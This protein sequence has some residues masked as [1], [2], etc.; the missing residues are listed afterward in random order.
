M[1]ERAGVPRRRISI[2]LGHPEAMKRAVRDGLGI[3][4]LFRSSVEQELE[5]GALRQLQFPDADFSSPI[6]LIHRKGK[7]FSAS[8]QDLLDAIRADISARWPKV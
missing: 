1:L 5:D 6:Y 8:Q 4:L 2:Q 7:L 3:A